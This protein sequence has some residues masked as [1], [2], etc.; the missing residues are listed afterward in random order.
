MKTTDNAAG[1][2]AGIKAGQ[3]QAKQDKQIIT[4]A[5][6]QAR[7]IALVPIYSIKERAGG[8]NTREPT[9]GDVE[10]MSQSIEALGLLEP[11]VVDMRGRLLAGKTRLE[12]LRQLAADNK[13]QWGRVPV[14]RLQVDADKNPELAL[15]IEAAENEQRRDYT[16][17]EI[18]AL[19]ERLTAAGYRET[20]G[21]PRKGQ[22]SLLPAL[23]TVVS[24]SKRQIMR[25]ISNQ[26]K[27]DNMTCVTFSRVTGNLTRALK[28]Y[29]NAAGK[30]EN[31]DARAVKAAGALLKMLTE[32]EG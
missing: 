1:M 25:I 12:A 32:Q 10:R 31:P 14:R 8:L 28:S 27:S 22:K 13:K 2:L 9:A 4:A 17:A 15:A 6:Q 20:R 23:E 30:E 19:A 7:E 29:L 21:R 24:K 26:P 18:R 3:E 5:D 11:L 16:A